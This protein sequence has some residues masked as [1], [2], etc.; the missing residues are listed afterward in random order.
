MDLTP[1]FNAYLRHAAIPELDLRFHPQQG[2][3]DYR[4][5]DDEPGFDMPIDVGDPT[6][7]TRITPNTT[8]WQTIEW[9]GTEAAFHVATDL[10]YVNVV[11]E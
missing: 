8:A 1:F 11:K 6:H 4:W 9:P 5:K 7:W 10:Y 3:V 2:T